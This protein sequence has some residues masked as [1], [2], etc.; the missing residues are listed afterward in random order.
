MSIK[1]Y[2]YSKCGTCRKALKW[3]D[4]HGVEYKNIP[5][6]EKPPSK[7]ALKKAYKASGLPLKKFFNTSGKSYRE[8]G[9]SAR[10]TEMSDDE[11][12]AALAADGKLIKRPLLVSED[13]VLVGFRE[14]EYADAFASS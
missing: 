5:I 14:T 10:L 12:L 1:V 4:E 3:L 2:A 13:R 6:V 9:F 11:K 7:T 8:G